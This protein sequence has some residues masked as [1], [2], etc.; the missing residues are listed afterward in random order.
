MKKWYDSWFC[1]KCKAENTKDATR[2]HQC[3][4]PKGEVE[5][6]LLKED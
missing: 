3:G 5:A 1:M 6:K 4:T 2:C